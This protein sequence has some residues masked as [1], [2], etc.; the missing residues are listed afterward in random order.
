MMVHDSRSGD[1]SFCNFYARRIRR[2]VPA[3]LVVY[4]ASAALAV[5][6]MLPT[7]AAELA[8]SLRSSA[9]FTSNIFFYNLA[10]YFGGASDLKPLLHTWSLSIE[11]Q[12]YLLWPLLFWMVTRWRD[13]LVLPFTVVVGAL[14]LVALVSASASGEH[15]EAAFFLTPFRVWELMLGAS[16]VLLPALPRLSTVAREISTALGFLLIIGSVLLIDETRTAPGL[17]TVPACFGTALLLL[18][19]WTGQPLVTRF[20]SSGPM[21]GVGL[22]SY[23]LYLWHWPLLSFARYQ[24]DRPLLLAETGGLLSLSLILALLTYRYVEQPARRVNL[25]YNRH[26]IGAG[27]A[28]LGA[29]TL[30]GHQMDKGGG[31]TFN[32][33][34]RIRQ[35]ETVARAENIYRRACN[36]QNNLSG[37]ERSCT[38][39]RAYSPGRYDIVIF[40]DSHGNHY[41]PTVE[42]MAEHRGWS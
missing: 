11:E 21:V 17:A 7:D 31:W 13:Q 12:F 9:W 14:S 39:G 34:P 19:G 4:L 6:L 25:Q 41:T 10:D 3:L 28:S 16:I 20:L 22:I 8:R 40:G 27:L 18:T 15:G 30:I 38:F 5:L 29:L 26:V 33:D 35:L 36:G 23:S 32:F 37:N 1:F 2:I 24:L 42:A